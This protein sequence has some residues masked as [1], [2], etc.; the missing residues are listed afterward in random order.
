MLN[1]VS[2][3]K[4]LQKT[5]AQTFVLF[6]V[7]CVLLAGLIWLAPNPQEVNG[8]ENII[9]TQNVTENLTEAVTEVQ[10]E[11]ITSLVAAQDDQNAQSNGF[12]NDLIAG[13]LWGG[14]LFADKIDT[15]QSFP[16]EPKQSFTTQFSTAQKIDIEQHGFNHMIDGLTHPHGHIEHDH[17][18]EIADVENILPPI[19]AAGDETTKTSETIK[20]GT[21]KDSAIKDSALKDSMIKIVKKKRPEVKITPKQARLN[22]EA[23][24]SEKRIYANDSGE[25]PKIAIVIDDL[26]MNYGRLKKLS[27]IRSPLTFA[28]L[29]YA[30]NLKDQTSYARLKGHELIVHMP[31]LPKS[32]TINP[33]PIVLTP[34]MTADQIRQT[35]GKG[36]KSFDGYV[37]IN[38]H[39]GSSFTEN[40]PAMRVVASELKKKG[41]YFLDSKTTSISAGARAAAYYDLP[42]IGRDIFLDHYDTLAFINKQLR[43]TERA[44]R[45][46]GHAIAIGHPY[47]N[48]IEALEKWLPTI[49][50]K[51]FDLVS[52]SDLIKQKKTLKVSTKQNSN[53]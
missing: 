34:D 45:K 12:F 6:A 47:L 15:A 49:E 16:S 50:A 44:A 8:Q 37:G 23:L 22:K 38:N 3:S 41:L 4:F 24:K 42:Y 10:P 43:A 40:Y 13:D 19:I 5:S 20:G 48:T 36:L 46:N 1:G 27:S 2:F 11:K 29:P 25:R 31:M 32:D 51:G 28:F 21:I 33:G 53:Q 39:M 17:G 18:G 30:K 9:V 35:L 26:G 52:V 7:F 14:T